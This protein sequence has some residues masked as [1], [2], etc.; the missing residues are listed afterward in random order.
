MLN[1]AAQRKKKN[2]TMETTHVNSARS[3][4]S[5]LTSN[6]ANSS[7]LQGAAKTELEIINVNNPNYVPSK[8]S[9]PA[10]RPDSARY[11]LLQDLRH[12]NLSNLINSSAEDAIEINRR[13]A[14]VFSF[15]DYRINLFIYLNYFYFM[16]SWSRLEKR[17]INVNLCNK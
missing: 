5:S 3:N 7:S 1:N 8:H 15:L 10:V 6:G 12:T 14:E 2:F 4:N 11:R 16:F 9:A 17:S 13:Q